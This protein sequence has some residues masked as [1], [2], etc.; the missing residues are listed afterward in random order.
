MRLRICS[1]LMTAS[2]GAALTL[3]SAAYQP[4]FAQFGGGGF[5][6]TGFGGGGLGGT[7]LGNTGFGGGGFGG[8]G[9]GQSGFGQSSFGQPSF[10]QQG[11]GQQGFGQQGFGQQG[12]IGGGQGGAG[13]RTIPG[14]FGGLGVSGA[15]ILPNYLTQPLPGGVGGAAVFGI[16]PSANAGVGGGGGTGG[17]GGLG[18]GLGGLGL[19]GIGGLGGLGG[20]LGRNQFG[21][22][23]QGQG[24]GQGKGTFRAAVRPDIPKDRTR[25][26]NISTQLQTRLSR[27][28]L[29]ERLKGTRVSYEGGDVVLRGTVASEADKRMMERLIQ[30][31]PGVNSVRNELAVA[32]PTLEQI[33]GSSSR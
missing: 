16:G 22:G 7:G 25:T 19:G 12:G 4:V 30:L 24:Q 17:I 29:P 31:E 20:G 18:G 10:G 3:C 1:R 33:P 2:L 26:A 6:G 11:F 28:P 27:V 14:Q 21:R 8:G 23:A 5:G 13:G 15:G 32:Q 9:F